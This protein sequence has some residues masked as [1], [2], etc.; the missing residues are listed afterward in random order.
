[1][2]SS[3]GLVNRLGGLWDAI[4][5][6]KVRAHIEKEEIEVTVA[7]PQAGLLGTLVGSVA[8]S[9]LLESK[10]P[11]LPRPAVL[12]ILAEKLGP[13]AWLLEAGHPQARLEWL[14]EVE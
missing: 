14:I 8:P 7:Q 5:A 4:S 11:S 3:T 13:S 6:A 2:R 10:L 9:M 1:M 12:E